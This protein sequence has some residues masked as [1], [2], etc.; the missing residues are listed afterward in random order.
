[1]P[2]VVVFPS[3][4]NMKRRQF[5][6]VRPGQTFREW[7]LESGIAVQMRAQEMVTLKNG[8]G[9]IEADWDKPLKDTDLIA[10]Q[11]TPGASA[12]ASAVS[13]VVNN[14]LLVSTIATAALSV[15]GLVNEPDIPEA[16]AGAQSPNHNLNVRSNRARLGEPKP[17]L[18]GRARVY[19]DL[20]SQPYTEFDANG[21]QTVWMLYEMSMGEVDI[22]E[23][24]LRFEDTPL[25]SFDSAT[26]EIIPPGSTSNLFT[27]EV[28]TS[29]SVSN[30]PIENA[31][32]G[33]Y[34]AN[35]ASTEI[36]SLSF[37]I[38]APTGLH[39]LRSEGKKERLT[40]GV[41]FEARLI[42]DNGVALGGWTVLGEPQ[43]SGYSSEQVR[44]TYR[45]Q[46]SRGRYEVRVTRFAPF[47]YLPDDKLQDTLQWVQLRG[48]F[49]DGLPVTDTTRI[50]IRMRDSAQIGGRALTKFSLVGTRKLPVWN[51]SSWSAPQ[52][53]RSAVW[54]FAEAC[55]ASYGGKRADAYI[56]LAELLALETETA[57][58][59]LNCDGVFDSKG[60]LWEALKRIAF[61]IDAVPIDEGGVYTM[62]RDVEQAAP[63]QMFNMRNTVMDSYAIDHKGV[64][65]ETAD[66]VVV[67]FYDE[68]QD[69]RLSKVDGLLPSGANAKPRIVR[70]WGIVNQAKAHRAAIRM[71]AVNRY[72]R[73]IHTWETGTEGRIPRWGEQ[74]RN[75]H[76]MIGA[77][78]SPQQSGDIIAYDAGTDR[79][80]LSEDV[81]G[82]TDPYI[83]L[84]TNTGAPRG[85]YPVTVIGPQLVEITG[86]YNASGLLFDPDYDL[87]K[88]SLGEGVT[89]D[90]LLK[91]ERLVPQANGNVRIEAYLDSPA[92]YSLIAGET[93]PTPK[94][95]QNL[96]RFTPTITNLVAVLGGSPADP[97]VYLSWLGTA[98]DRY[99]V[100][101][102]VD[103]GVNWIDMGE[104]LEATK[105]IDAPEHR[106]NIRYRVAGVSVFQGPWVE[107][108]VDTV[109]GTYLADPL[110]DGA[111]IAGA[112]GKPGLPGASKILFYDN[113]Q[114]SE[115]NASGR[116]VFSTSSD[117]ADGTFDW[118]ILTV[119]NGVD[120]LFL[121][122]ADKDARDQS[123]Y[124]EQ[125]EVGD[126]VT[127]LESSRRWLEFRVTSADV[128]GGAQRFGI[129]LVE[130]DEAAG[131]T[132][133]LGA[134]GLVRE[135]RFSRAPAGIDGKTLVSNVPFGYGSYETLPD[136]ETRAFAAGATSGISTAGG[137][138]GTH[139]LNM[140]RPDNGQVGIWLGQNNGDY[141]WRFLPNKVW[142]IRAEIN[143]DEDTTVRFEVRLSD[144]STVTTAGVL[145][146]GGAGWVYA[147]FVLDLSASSLTTGI[148]SFR[149]QDSGPNGGSIR[150]DAI[151]MFLDD[152]TLPE[153][154][155]PYVPPSEGG[156]E[157]EDGEDGETTY[158][159]FAYAD[160]ITG[161][162][163]FT[164]G[165]GGSRQYIGIAANQLSP[166]ESTNPAAYTWQKHVGTDGV[167]GAPGDDG[168]DRW[169][170]MA[171][172]D[173]DT[174]TLNFTTGASNGREYVGYLHNQLTPIEGTNP[175]AYTWA[176]QKGDKGDAGVTITGYPS[177]IRGNG[178][179]N[180]SN[181]Q[182]QGWQPPLNPGS[183]SLELALDGVG[184]GETITFSY[185]FPGNV[186]TIP[187]PADTTNMTITPFA[188]NSSNSS[189]SYIGF[190]VEYTPGG[191]STGQIFQMVFTKLTI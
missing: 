132:D 44:R 129:E 130:Y 90:E 183:M 42:D 7:T 110:N 152:G 123:A 69:Y 119:A 107:V 116:Y 55:R 118:S 57:P 36:T 31:V 108:Q 160:N 185:T 115:V 45:Y 64:L 124:F 159:W 17:V 85:P 135:F 37:D 151:S 99:D 81:S 133:L 28:T 165:D 103:G 175:A 56:N 128:V 126:V 142:R 72:R 166:I 154:E 143:N 153:G 3:P 173:N 78:G 113:A 13:W 39:R 50:G 20:S 82:Y 138:F 92:V 184:T 157:G 155:L 40:V 35:P 146:A 77:Q 162:S 23:A 176:K 187:T 51:G 59:G 54:A 145:V 140:F 134:D 46:L 79:L 26:Y 180:W 122:P 95:L 76:Y 14:W 25:S 97:D 141:R 4:F 147:E 136:I 171:F 15:Y 16:E 106:G 139:Y 47:Q 27:Q 191:S 70:L 178:V 43:L 190:N 170:W 120:Y 168:E 104:D 150:C 24:S 38:V 161:T 68:D 65:E 112:D 181:F 148:V 63:T 53:T 169:T 22:E 163:N 91:I 71:G 89:F 11:A 172:A 73:E 52:A 18:M 179:Q 12:I 58:L 131:D 158:T 96:Q 102:S 167:P 86:A 60:T 19:P 83:V 188:G 177:W 93:P 137:A 149:S 109:N 48:Y 88:F 67:E 5:H 80:T 1:M 164:T 121:N 84:P 111:G 21:D 33:P 66:H 6:Q 29:T 49:A 127:W 87:P 125:V 94:A 2:N 41:R 186:L 105:L 30:I 75:S 189:D 144:G 98:S 100:E 32:L 101:F 156:P 10:V 117:I 9:F 182:G 8:D 114:S 174:G 61:C 74:V 62:L 34:A